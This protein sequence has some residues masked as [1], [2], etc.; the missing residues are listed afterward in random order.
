MCLAYAARKQAYKAGWY[1][2]IDNPDYIDPMLDGV[3][4][5]DFNLW[6]LQAGKTYTFTVRALV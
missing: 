5:A 1:S 3:A 6:T 2:P 4:T